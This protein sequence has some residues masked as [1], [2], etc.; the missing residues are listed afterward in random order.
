MNKLRLLE[1][2]GFYENE[3]TNNLLSFWLP[4]SIDTENGGFFNCFTNDGSQLLSRDKYTWS[5]GRFVWTFARLAMLSAPIFSQE[6]KADFLALAKAG[7]E[8]LQKHCLVA[9]DDWRCVYLTDEKGTPKQAD[10]TGRLDLS[11]YAD[12]FVIAA[13]ARYGLAAA[14]KPAYTFASKLYQSALARI[15][16]GNYLTHPYPL[17]AQYR[18]HGIPMIM[19]NVTCEMIQAAAS[20]D[21]AAL[22]GLKAQLDVFVT[23]IL[24]NFASEND[25]IHEVIAKDNT[26]LPNMLGQHANPGHTIE[27]MWFVIEAAQLLDRPDLVRRA[28]AISKRTCAIGWDEEYGGLLHYSHVAGGPPRGSTAGVE[29]EPMLQQVLAGWSDKL[30]WVHSEAI[31][32]NLLCYELTG[33]ADFLA[34]YNKLASYTFSTFPN[35]DRTIREWIQIRQQDG[36]PQEKVVALPVKDPYHIMRNVIQIIELLDQ[37]EAKSCK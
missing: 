7:L 18:A 17:S 31:Y 22:P 36:T 10:E 2:R 3:L 5:Q 1:L 9:P 12:C 14:D 21:P 35:P 33:E 29:D 11:I 28:A 32:T 27:C 4:R 8:F 19:S 23:D 20:L 30:W 25:V 6:Q 26:Y 15:K 34:L 37:M 24:T 13:F 16:E